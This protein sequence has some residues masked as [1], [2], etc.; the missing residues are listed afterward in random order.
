MGSKIKTAYTTRL[1]TSDAENITSL[2]DSKLN[3]TS[4]HSVVD[5]VGLAVDNL[6]SQIERMKEG[7]RELEYLIKRTELQKDLIK[8]GSSLWLTECGLDKL[9]GDIISS[10]SI[11]QPKAK[12]TL[13]VINEESLINQGYF[14]QV[15][16]KTAV[17]QAILNGEEIEGAEIEVEHQ[18]FTLRINKRKVNAPTA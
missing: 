8:I 16:D 1:E 4:S 15:L 18:S 7:K 6:D 2:L 14:K 13:K 17:K 11:S 12:E 3:A 5:Y 9:D 10:M